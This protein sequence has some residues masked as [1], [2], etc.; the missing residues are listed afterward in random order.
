MYHGIIVTVNNKLEG[1]GNETTVA[2]FKGLFR[3]LPGGTEENHTKLVGIADICNKV[4][5]R[6]LPNMQQAC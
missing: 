3:D 6:D 1:M 4:Q 5:I 2:L